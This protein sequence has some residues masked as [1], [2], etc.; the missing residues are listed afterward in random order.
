M[1]KFIY[2]I[3]NKLNGKIYIGQ[4]NNPTRRFQEHRARGYGQEGEKILYKAFDKY[5]ISNFSFEI[6]EEVENYNEREK[7]WIK[8]YN[9][10]NPNGYNMSEGGENPPVFHGEKHPLCSHSEDTV[11]LVKKMLKETKISSSDIAKTTGYNTSSINR[12]NLG[13]LWFDKN[14]IY[15][16]R[17][18]GTSQGKEERCLAIIGDLLHTKMTQKEIAYKYGVSRTTVTALNRGQN[19]KQPNLDYPL[20]KGRVTS[21]GY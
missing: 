12:I 19:F 16:L 10:I 7:Y 17:K 13:E 4:T 21:K 5:G 11:M 20:R 18:D 3:T 2:K 8:F 15:P 14:E 9:C 1:K 6:I